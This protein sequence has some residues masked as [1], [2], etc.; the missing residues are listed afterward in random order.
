MRKRQ[1]SPMPP[2]APPSGQP[3]LDLNRTALVEVT[4]EEDGYPIESALLEGE[5]RG[6][7]AANP[8]PQTI[9]LVFDEPQKHRRIWL[10]FEDS[11]NARTQE[12]VLRW[13][14]D[15]G[16]SFREIVRQQWNFS[17]PNSIRETEDYPV[18]LS[19]VTA[20]ELM[21]VPDTAGGQL[22][23]RSPASV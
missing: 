14:P 8:G 23:H 18:E 7:R 11:E 10:A 9:R 13:F 2:S 12:F 20:L 4:S 5:D 3:W 15:A 6:W 21:I 16:H 19:A 17:P 1:I 22:L